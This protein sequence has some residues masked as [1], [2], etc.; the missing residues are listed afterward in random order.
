MPERKA[1][2][3]LEVAPTEATISTFSFMDDDDVVKVHIP[4][5]GASSLP[6]GSISCD[7]RE[8]SFDL[9]VRNS[10]TSNEYMITT[11]LVQFEP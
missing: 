10:M 2:T 3:K 9:R 1:V 6:V 11:M 8:R 5:P 4:L 7:F